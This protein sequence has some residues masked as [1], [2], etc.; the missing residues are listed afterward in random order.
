HANI[1][2]EPNADV[3]KTLASIETA[4]KMQFTGEAYEYT[5]VDSQLDSYYKSENRLYTLFRIFS[6]LAILISCIGLWGLV[7]YAAQ[8][9]TKEIGIR[10]VLGASVKAILILLAKDFLVLISISI[11]IAT[12]LTYYFMNDWLSNFAF[13]IDMGWITFFIAGM[14]LLSVALLTVTIQTVKAALTN[15]V[16]SL[17]A[18]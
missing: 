18:E 1:K 17:K 5:F 14:A 10:K 11:T 4:W 6:A 9:R 3:Q 8:Q 7:T 16:K 2:I 13:H 15:P 12:P